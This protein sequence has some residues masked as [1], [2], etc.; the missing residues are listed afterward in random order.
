M[1]TRAFSVLVAGT[2]VATLALTGCG[3]GESSASSGVKPSLPAGSTMEKLAEAGKIKIGAS[4][5]QPGLSETD[6]SGKWQGFNI[7]LAEYLVGKLGLDKGDIEWV[8]T[9]AANRIPFIQ[10]GKIDVFATALAI[11]PEREKAISIAGPWTEASPRLI[12]RKADAGT[13][14]NVK[15]LP[16][17]KKVCVLQGSQGEP[18][19]SKELPQAKIV[20][21]D[22]LTKCVSALRQGTVDAVDSTAPLLAGYVAKEPNTFAFVPGTYGTGEIWGLGVAKNRKD[23]CQFFNKELGAA[24]DDGTI[25]KLWAEHM[26]ASGLDAPSR[27]QSM[28]HC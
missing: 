5:D 11:T 27:H 15:A 1:R 10:Q 22:V 23:L 4:P 24:F 16:A 14:A 6:L 2:A 18:R 21:F 28:D 20:E 19:V 3:G 17:G 13:W 7:D 26:G 9:T 8:N 12:A 25:K